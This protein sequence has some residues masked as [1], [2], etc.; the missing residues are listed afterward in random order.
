MTRLLLIALL[1]ESGFVLL[2]V[3]WSSFWDRNYFAASL[4]LLHAV[5][6]N[7]FIR[8]AISGLGVVNLVAGIVDLYSLL[9]A[10]HTGTA[11]RSGVV[12]PRPA[13]ED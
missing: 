2:V 6:T 9:S 13:A 10:R 1:L 7:N 11:H 4:P 8:G 5:I 12:P 3:P